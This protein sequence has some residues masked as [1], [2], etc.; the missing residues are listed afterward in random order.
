VLDGA[1]PTRLTSLDQG[2]AVPVEHRACVR[3]LG[4]THFTLVASAAIVFMLS[5][6]AFALSSNR[7]LTDSHYSMLLSEEIYRHDDVYLDAYFKLPL[8]PAKYPGIASGAYP[9]MIEREQGH[10]FYFYPP[11]SSILSVP[12]VA[13]LNQYGLAPVG[14]DQVYDQNGELAIQGRIAA[15]LMAVFAA[16]VFLTAY[17]LTGSLR[18]S[19]VLALGTALGTQIWSTASRVLWSHTWGVLLLGLAIL[20][21]VGGEQRRWRVN[22]VVLATLMAWTFLVRPTNAIACAV[23]GIYVV[24]R[25][26]PI[27]M[28][29]LATSLLWIGA[30]VLYSEY[31]F[32]TLVPAEYQQGG[33]FELNA[34]NQLQA[35]AGLLVSPSRGLLIFCPVLLVVLFWLIRHWRLMPSHALVLV[36]ASICALQLVL[37]SSWKV[38]WGGFA[39]G[40]RLLTDLVPWLALLAI[41][42]VVAWRRAGDAGTAARRRVRGAEL[43]IAGVLLGLSVAINWRGATSFATAWW[44]AYPVSLEVA[45]GRVWDWSQ[46]QFLATNVPGD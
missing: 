32:G 26:R 15:L 2:L 19:Y 10:L 33:G 25:L 42:A 3:V 6:V 21:L 44:N 30:F 20:Y 35:L 24:L 22:P 23:V 46:P 40:P 34:A 29:Y 11:G 31:Y 4:R 1:T 5:F 8:D 7:Q 18:W 16:W 37:V 14:A 9:Y 38:W 36:A 13:V 43:L 45:P 12:F 28:G 17:L 41:A 39:Y 27:L